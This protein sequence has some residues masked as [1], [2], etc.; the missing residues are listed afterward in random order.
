MRNDSG[1]IAIG[2][3][4]ALLLDVVIS[5]NLPVLAGNPNFM[6]AYAL[7]ISILSRGGIA[8]GVAFALG[9]AI[10]LLGFGP[11]GLMSI[12]L[13]AGVFVVRT[14][15]SDF[16]GIRGAGSVIAL[17]LV[18]LGVEV[19]HA[20]GTVAMMS[21]VNPVDA[22]AY[23]ALPCSVLTCIVGLF[24]YLIMRRILYPVRTSFGQRPPG[25]RRF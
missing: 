4:V 10:D 5:P 12:L 21:D 23:L 13:L 3:V 25:L 24:T 19:L 1:I 16:S 22:V 8:Y 18:I 9:M 14:Y 15:V 6:L 17:F 7:V 11:V 20:L 2:A